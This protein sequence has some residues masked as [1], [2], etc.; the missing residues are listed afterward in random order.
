MTS[1]D[2]TVTGSFCEG[3][4]P[5]LHPPDAP[6]E[7]S[8]RLMPH[9]NLAKNQPGVT[10]TYTNVMLLVEIH[11]FEF[12]NIQQIYVRVSELIG[13]NP[14]RLFIMWIIL[15]SCKSHVSKDYQRENP[16][17]ALTEMKSAPGPLDDDD[18]SNKL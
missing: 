5:P 4:S 11:V 12:R 6:L 16:Q 15:P 8:Q 3:A 2:T 13:Q 17:F 10:R 7:P 18:G 9:W 1:R 14:G